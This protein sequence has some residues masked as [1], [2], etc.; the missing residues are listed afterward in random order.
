MSE[1]KGNTFNMNKVTVQKLHKY[2]LNR[3]L[4]VAKILNRCGKDMAKKYGLHHWDNS[5]IK[6]CIIVLL[7]VLKNEIYLVLDGE[8]PIA[9]FQTKKIGDVL[10]FEKLAVI[11]E[12][13]GNGYGSHCIKLI[14]EQARKLGCHHVRMEVYEQSKHAIEFY[15]HKGYSKVGVTGTLR[16]TNLVMEK[17]L[18]Q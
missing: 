12:V 14:E 7:C 16:Y 8:E 15:I 17:E 9:T 5:R 4:P 13:S 18:E 3:L 10:F 1:A 2:E 11:P 6:S